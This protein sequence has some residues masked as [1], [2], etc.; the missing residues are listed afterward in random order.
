MLVSARSRMRKG[1]STVRQFGGAAVHGV[2][3]VRKR[4]GEGV[5]GREQVPGGIVGETHGRAV[6]VLGAGAPIGGVVAVGRDLGLP[7]GDGRQVA[8]AVVG[9]ALEAGQ[10]IRPGLQPV[11]GVVGVGCGLGLGVGHGEEVPVGVVGEPGDAAQRVGG[12]DEVVENVVAGRRSTLRPRGS[13]SSSVPEG[14]LRDIPMSRH[15]NIVRDAIG[16]ERR[17]LP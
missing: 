5:G 9:E 12:G 17:D 16:I 13:S 7:I 14:P 8:V 4:P 6:R 15:R 11:Q 3:R 1:R 2:V 10:G